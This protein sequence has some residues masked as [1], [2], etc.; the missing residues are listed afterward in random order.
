MDFRELGTKHRE[1]IILALILIVSLVALSLQSSR[2]TSIPQRIGLGISST[3]ERI[4]TGSGK[5]ISRTV[6]SI[7]ELRDLRAEYTNLLSELE[8]SRQIFQSME[9]LEAENEQLR[10]ALA[11]SRN[12]EFVHSPAEIIGKDPGISFT[13][14]L[15]NKGSAHGIQA[16]MPVVGFQNGKQ[17]LVGKVIEVSRYASLVRPLVDPESY[18][19][20]RLSR[21]R[22]EG[23]LRGL[24][25]DEDLLLMEYVDRE[26]RN[27]ISVGDEV[28]TSGLDSVY[29]SNIRIGTISSI[30]A[31][32][33]STSLE[34]D[35][36]PYIQYSR[37]EHVF[38]IHTSSQ[39]AGS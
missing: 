32:S 22:Y 17:G 7:S 13:S 39:K 5:F 18:V 2:F 16:G 31:K 6:N 27:Q 1:S 8:K 14:L 15:V 4:F 34:L 30:N 35:V 19:S 11:Y 24:G 20:A 12:S 9:A 3:V 10:S 29:P 21:T 25:S 33:Y 23:L 26:S 37:L 28:I 38:I 36:V